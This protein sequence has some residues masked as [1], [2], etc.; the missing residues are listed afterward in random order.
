[1]PK[2]MQRYNWLLYCHALPG[3]QAKE[4]EEEVAKRYLKAKSAPKPAAAAR[5]PQDHWR[6]TD[7]EGYTQVVKKAQRRK[8]KK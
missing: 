2:Q 7:E 1:M 3:P 6:A 4:S 5:N 8:Q